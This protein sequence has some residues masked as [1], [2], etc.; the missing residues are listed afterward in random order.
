[1]S[2]WDDA[3]REVRLAFD[4]FAG[5]GLLYRQERHFWLELWRAA[6]VEAIEEDGVEMRRYGPVQATVLIAA[7][8]KPQVNLVLGSGEPGAV[9]DGH[10]AEALDWIESLGIDCRIPIRPGFEESE[11]AEDLL[12]L[13]GYHRAAH[14]VRF[15]RDCSAPGFPDPPGIEVDEW[16]EET[17]G[18]S[19]YFEDGFE[20][21]FPGS[22]FFGALPGRLS[23]RCYVA[24]DEKEGG[25]GA[26]L[27]MM[28][29]ETAQLAFATTMD[30]VRGRGV[31]MAL[32]RRRIIDAAATGR[33]KLFADTEEPVDDLDG[34]SRGARNLLRAGFKQLAARPVWRPPL[35]PEDEE[36]DDDEDD[37]DHEDDDFDEDHDFEF[38]D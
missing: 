26:A 2:S 3:K 36:E 38:E 31:H 25:A 35:P 21:D 37:D 27:M 13:R 1:M 9:S 18:F 6:P 20:L 4:S 7:P 29:P 10:L 11:A 23:W 34:P 17:E 22:C 15:V 24:V 28:H 33:S 8:R 16:T 12:A 19:D 14:L 5:P 30:S 32:L